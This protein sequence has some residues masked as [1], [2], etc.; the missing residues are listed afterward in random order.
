VWS[1]AGYLMPRGVLREAGLDP[2]QVFASQAFVG[3]YGAVLDALESGRAD[4]GATYCSL[5]ENGALTAAPWSERPGLRPI[6]LSGAI[7]GDAICAAG[8]LSPDDAE[9]M[10]EPLIALSAEAEGQTLLRRLFGAERFAEVDPSYYQGL[11]GM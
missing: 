11:E 6:A 7:P 5:D 2:A 3:S 1:A 4:L 8:E 9:A 10:V